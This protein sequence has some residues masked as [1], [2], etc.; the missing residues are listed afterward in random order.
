M[1]TIT[2]TVVWKEVHPGGKIGLLEV[3]GVD[4]AGPAPALEQE[5]RAIERRL[6]EKFAD[7]PV[8]IY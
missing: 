7:S 5:K 8:K 3:S 1:L 2:T 6:R 4:N